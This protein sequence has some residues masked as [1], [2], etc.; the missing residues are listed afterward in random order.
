MRS[1]AADTRSI[2]GNLAEDPRLS[3]DAGS[4]FDAAS[5]GEGKIYLPTI[6]LVE[7]IYLA[8]KGRIPAETFSNL[9]RVIGVRNSPI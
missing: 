9:E 8:E 4:A 5:A 6:C 7:T 2:I 1:V 3:T